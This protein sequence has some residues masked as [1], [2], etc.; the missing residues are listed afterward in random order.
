MWSA[1]ER[2][3]ELLDLTSDDP[4]H[5]GPPRRELRRVREVVCD[6]FVGNN[7]Y[8]STPESLMTYFL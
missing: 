5:T 1:L 3:L 6:F 4:R 2:A 8:H 7:E